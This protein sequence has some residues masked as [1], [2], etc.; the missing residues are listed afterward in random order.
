MVSPLSTGSM[1][2]RCFFSLSWII[3]RFD[4]G[5]SPRGFLWVLS[6][7]EFAQL[8]ECVRL[9]LLPNL[10]SFPL[11]F[12]PHPLSLRLLGLDVTDIRSFVIISWVPR[13][14]FIFLQSV[15]SQLST[16]RNSYYSVFGSQTRSLRHLLFLC[17]NF[18]FFHWFWAYS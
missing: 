7:L 12:Q 2:L 6:H 5:A 10:G 18:L 8:L 13:T 3:W 4:C 11:W 17:W 14:L 1:R 9:C 15:I 16:L